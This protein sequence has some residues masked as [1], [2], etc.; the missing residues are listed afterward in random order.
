MLCYQYDNGE[1]VFNQ[2]DALSLSFSRAYQRYARRFARDIEFV[3]V[4]MSDTGDET[5]RI[6][7]S[8]EEHPEFVGAVAA[9]AG[10]DGGGDVVAVVVPHAALADDLTEGDIA[11]MVALDLAAWAVENAPLP[12]S[13]PVEVARDVMRAMLAARMLSRAGRFSPGAENAGL[14]SVLIHL[15][16]S[17]VDAP[18]SVRVDALVRKVLDFAS[19]GASVGAS[20]GDVDVESLAEEA[21]RFLGV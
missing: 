9:A 5:K 10:C 17:A 1:V 2:A 6:L 16:K 12:M 4:V 11:T 7:L 19:A 8:R 21:I 18:P 3:P 20:V 14:A 13:L 15:L